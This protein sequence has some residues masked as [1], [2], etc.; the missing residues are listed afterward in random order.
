MR[1][2]KRL[3]YIILLNIIISAVTVLV[4]L[5]VWEHDHPPIPA[6]ATPVV[7][8]VTPTQAEQ[9]STLVSD[10]GL[11]DET[12][13]ID[14]LPTE[15]TLPAIPTIELLTYQVKEGD[16]LGALATQFNVSV[17]DLLMVNN[18]D[19]P[20]SLYIGQIIYIPTAPLPRSTSTSIPPTVVAS[21]TPKPSAT[22]TK[23]PGFTPTQTVTGQASQMVI[24]SVIGAG[25]LESEHVVLMHS[26]DGEL[27]MAGWRIEDGN[28]N[29]YTFPQLTLYKGGSINL[30]TRSGEDTVMDLFWG[31]PTA[32][33]D[34]GK[35]VYLY[36]SQ[37]ELRAVYSV[38]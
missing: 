31:L 26:G 29:V 3:F 12:P 36:D 28:G 5:R 7:I 24:Y 9:P 33:W 22:A 13:F 4:V 23:K 37:H 11:S 6:E 19:D 34:S 18:L 2:V 35:T 10:P 20:D 25:V 8:V 14:G 16:T 32:I 27:S 30:N 38:P 15:G 17:A 21:A 1:Q